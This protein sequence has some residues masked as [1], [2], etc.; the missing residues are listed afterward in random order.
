MGTDVAIH[1]TYWQNN[2]GEPSSR[3]C[4]NASPD[5]AK[6]VSRWRQPHV[7]YDPGDVT[8][9]WLGATKVFLEDKEVYLF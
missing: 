5:D 7:P 1:S 9:E 2:Y 6:W 3:D 4:V 8:I